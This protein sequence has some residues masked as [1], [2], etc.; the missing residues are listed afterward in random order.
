MT[1]RAILLRSWL[2]L[3]MLAS[4]MAFSS[5]V[6][7]QDV[8]PCKCDVGTIYVADDVDCKFEVCVKDHAGFYCYW[9]GPGSVEQFKCHDEAV[10]Y[11]KDCNGNLVQINNNKTN[12]VE[13]VC[14]GKGC[15]VDACVGFDDNGCIV[16]KIGRSSCKGC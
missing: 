8:L 2:L 3:G 6:Q 1:R 15:C 4:L 16:V 7:A 11:L 12:C 14:V 13:C 9:V 5:N 10:I